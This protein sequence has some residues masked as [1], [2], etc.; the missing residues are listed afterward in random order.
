MNATVQF[1][2]A[3]TTASTPAEA[4]D[5]LR[6]QVEP[7]TDAPGYDLALLFVSPHHQQ[8]AASLLAS[9][10]AAW[11]PSVLI[12]CVGVGVIGA[13]EELERRPAITALVG[14]LPGARLHP[15]N[16][17]PRD[18]RVRPVLP[19]SLIPDAPPASE[20]RLILLMADPFSMPM[21][22]TLDTMNLLFAGTPVVGGMA[23]GGRAPDQTML[24]LNGDIV[25]TG[26]IGVA[27]TGDL[28]VDLIVSQ[29]CRPVG[30][31]YDVTEAEE[32]V[33]LSLEDETPLKRIQDLVT[34]LP[35]EERDL[36]RNGLF[37]GRAID[38][39][40]ERLGRGDFL[41]RGVM[42][43]DQ[44]TG[45]IAVGDEIRL[46]EKVQFHVRDARTAQEDLELMLSPQ[47]IFGRPSAGIV[48]SCNGRGSQLY[49]HP[50]G[51]IDVIQAA[52]GG[53]PVAGFFC[54]G[55]IGPIGGRNFLHGHTAS[56]A[57]L[58]AG[59][60]SLRE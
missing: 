59:A 35:D 7:R 1:A 57:L 9:L 34:D 58:R 13:N 31:V 48:F 56:I 10:R 40:R 6:R 25:T 55:E 50:N 44:K 16:I 54:A 22:A 15:F 45:A 26:A 46:G 11:N 21:D 5:D 47:G 41:I 49:Q 43:I 17:Q 42:G 32:N 29:G 20:I 37:I 33:I 12:G 18:L 28:E 53:I 51:D 52:L 19:G 8:H 27:I 2:S 24:F 3:T 60:R 14:S 4:V 23:S 38:S 30:P 39:D 36:L